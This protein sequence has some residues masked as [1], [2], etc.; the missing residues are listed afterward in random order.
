MPSSAFSSYIVRESLSFN[1]IAILVAASFILYVL[2]LGYYRLYLS[3]L[4]SV[5][6]PKLAALTGWVEAYYELLHGEGGQF[7]FKYREWHEKY[8]PIVRITPYEVHIQDASFYDTLYA[9]S[10]ASMKRKE[11][12]HRFNN[13]TSAF[14][15]PDH[16]LHR[17]RRGALNPFFSK[18]AI[19]ERAQSIQKQMDIVSERLKTEFQNTDRILVV[20]E[21]WG[22]FA[23]D[24]ITEYCFERRYDFIREPNFKASFVKSFIDLLDGVHWVT[25]FPWLT[26]MMNWMPDTT[27]GWIDPRMESVTRFNNEML[28]QVSEV[29]ENSDSKEKQNTIFASIIRSDMP[30]AEVTPQRLQHEAIA[31]VGAGL[32]TTMRTL[33]VSVYHIIDNRSIYHRLRDELFTAIPDPEKIPSW[34]LLQQLPFLTACIEESLRLSYGVAQRSPRLHDH[35]ITYGDFVIPKGTIISMSNYDVSHDE[36]IFP[37]SFEYRPE[38]WL[39]NPRSSDGRRLSRYMVSFGRG[40]RSCLGMQLAYAE[41]FVGLATVFRRF[42][43]EI[44]D[45]DR[46]DVDAGRDCFV[47]RPVKRSN[48][49]RV[50]VK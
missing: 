48:G 41:L 40:T 1:T 20:N 37:N 31:V 12:E 16:A 39:G 8:G 42:S 27:I 25:Q 10:R 2:G 30:R 4:A 44:Y 15:T 17:L 33:T 6:G 26:T 49:V 50:L 13:P 29:I 32:E 43:F 14:V 45:T 35:D 24:I 47:P 22:C 21:M 38:R 7:M 5:P 23:T 46:T 28:A 36:T 9:T 3:P 19:S 18:R 11:F 34:E